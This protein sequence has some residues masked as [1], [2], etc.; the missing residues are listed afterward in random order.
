MKSDSREKTIYMGSSGLDP[1]NQ[2]FDDR[3]RLFLAYLRH[4][5]ESTWIKTEAVCGGGDTG[6][7]ERPVERFHSIEFN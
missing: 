2:W 1:V 6:E 3:A 7:S 5:T 4:F